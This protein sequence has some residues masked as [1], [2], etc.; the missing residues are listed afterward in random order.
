M[1]ESQASLPP[2]RTRRKS[3]AEQLCSDELH[4]IGARQLTTPR[5]HDKAIADFGTAQ[6]KLYAVR[7]EAN[8][9]VSIREQFER[10]KVVAEKH[11]LAALD[12]ALNEA[13]DILHNR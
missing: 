1:P 4:L 11:Y 7:R 12:A 9:K 8:N 5:D 2:K 6:D 10:D 13:I 3:H